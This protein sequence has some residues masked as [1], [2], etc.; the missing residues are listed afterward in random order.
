MMLAQCEIA[1]L[2]I[3]VGVDLKKIATLV[4]FNRTAFMLM[5]S[6]VRFMST[7]L[8]K[9]SH[10]CDQGAPNHDMG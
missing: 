5:N 10:L 2:F 4:T 9:E 1:P 3:D 6:M 8:I 7:M